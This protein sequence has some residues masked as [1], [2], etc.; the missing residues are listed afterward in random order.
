LM[1]QELMSSSWKSW[2]MRLKLLVSAGGDLSTAAS[3]N[4]LR[5]TLY[6]MQL[7]TTVATK[8]WDNP[9]PRNGLY[10]L[11][12]HKSGRWGGQNHSLEVR[13]T[14]RQGLTTQQLVVL[15]QHRVACD[16]LKLT[17][18]SIGCCALCS[19]CMVLVARPGVSVQS[20]GVISP[21][22]LVSY[23]CCICTPL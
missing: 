2:S 6:G 15:R 7:L 11:D 21:T 22:L 1:A 8:W 18:S 9:A 17:S 5:K 4:T 13:K 14:Q 19:E 16:L 23:S 3:E 20:H 10:I 12:V